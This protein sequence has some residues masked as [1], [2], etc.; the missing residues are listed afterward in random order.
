MNEREESACEMGNSVALERDDGQTAIAHLTEDLAGVLEVKRANELYQPDGPVPRAFRWQPFEDV[1]T[2]CV[3]LDAEMEQV[4][5][6]TRISARYFFSTDMGDLA[7]EYFAE[8]MKRGHASACL[9]E[10]NGIQ[11]PPKSM[12]FHLQQ[13][14]QKLYNVFIAQVMAPW[15]DS[16]Y[17]DLLGNVR[18]RSSLNGAHEVFA[19]WELL[20]KQKFPPAPGSETSTVRLI[21][22]GFR[23][24]VA[25]LLVSELGAM[26]DDRDAI[27]R[28][29]MQ[30]LGLY[31]I[32]R[33]VQRLPDDDN[34]AQRGYRQQVFGGKLPQQVDA[35]EYY[36]RVSPA[37]ANKQLTREGKAT[38]AQLSQD[39][40]WNAVLNTKNK[41][42]LLATRVYN[43]DTG[44]F[45]TTYW[46]RKG[47]E[48]RLGE[49]VSREAQKLEHATR[50]AWLRPV[51]DSSSTSP[52][53][54]VSL[55]AE[56]IAQ[57][58]HDVLCG[59][60]VSCSFKDTNRMQMY[61]EIDK[62]VDHAGIQD[63]MYNFVEDMNAALGA[64]LGM[65]EAPGERYNKPHGF[66]SKPCVDGESMWCRKT[67]LSASFTYTPC[68]DDESIN[69]WVMNIWLRSLPAE[70]ELLYSTILVAR[71]ADYITRALTRS[72]MVNEDHLRQRVQDVAAVATAL[73][74]ANRDSVASSTA[75]RDWEALAP[76]EAEWPGSTIPRTVS[77]LLVQHSSYIAK[78]YQGETHSRRRGVSVEDTR[79]MPCVADNQVNPVGYRRAVPP[80]IEATYSDDRHHHQP[81][82]A[83][84]SVALDPMA[85]RYYAFP[86][87]PTDLL[88][89]SDVFEALTSPAQ[90]T[91][92]LYFSGSAAS[93][94]ARVQRNGDQDNGL[95]V[96]CQ[97]AV[98]ASQVSAKRIGSVGDI[99]VQF[100]GTLDELRGYIA[101][102]KN[103][104]RV[105]HDESYSAAARGSE[106]PEQV[107]AGRWELYV[108]QF[109]V[110][111]S[112]EN[113][114]ALRAGHVRAWERLVTGMHHLHSIYA[115]DA[116]G[117]VGAVSVADVMLAPMSDPDQIRSHAIYHLLKSHIETARASSDHPHIEDFDK[118]FMDTWAR[119]KPF[120]R[121]D[122]ARVDKWQLMY[123][124]SDHRV[125]HAW[126]R[127]ELAEEYSELDAREQ[128]KPYPDD[129]WK[130]NMNRIRVDVTYDVDTAFISNYVLPAQYVR[131]CHK[132]PCTCGKWL[133]ERMITTDS[134]VYPM[135]KLA[136]LA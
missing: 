17:P 9:T 29:Y 48:Q 125:I 84:P 97:D 116:S 39:T 47:P 81:M 64:S 6:E 128:T 77:N 57:P 123:H 49:I 91:D 112:V 26:F 32:E 59:A 42:V 25:V 3:R 11:A 113:L 27:A 35:L 103:H 18:D 60:C 36:T 31:Y 44:V 68:V 72:N 93:Q 87:T 22:F 105:S 135:G 127:A 106:G 43:D 14:H 115:R 100:N 80:H 129:R 98:P 74:E 107:D 70:T 73:I 20:L 12:L 13:A 78:V 16:R 85:G 114:D 134:H 86:Q 82:V 108:R 52:E 38:R 46:R 67:Y 33:V 5:E 56:I 62:G 131:L 34:A 23:R 118:F 75:L 15:A 41:G 53:A 21:P 90:Y 24:L 61:C 121:T 94:L 95:C 101:Q 50:S 37:D 45:E 28:A 66:G 136:H 65:L 63:L 124:A 54:L 4:G 40:A 133:L 69:V 76:N 89:P 92:K 96:V 71:A 58:V 102:L 99:D 109:E 88:R 119:N 19:T 51:T 126:N 1:D 130:V 8:L 10:C 110:D 55:A 79:L 83:L 120:A 122:F 111:T 30:I 117:A 2:E 132:Q 104:E 7:R